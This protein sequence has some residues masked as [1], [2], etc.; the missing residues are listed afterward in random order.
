MRKSGQKCCRFLFFSFQYVNELSGGNQGG[1]ARENRSELLKR[2]I[3]LGRRLGRE[4][5]EKFYEL[6]DRSE[7]HG[8]DGLPVETC[9]LDDRLD[10]DSEGLELTGHF[11]LRF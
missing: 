2:K 3:P 10:G 6:C 1:Q 7:L 4:R 8:F 5:N 9:R 11:M